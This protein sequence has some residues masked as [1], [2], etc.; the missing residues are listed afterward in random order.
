[1]SSWLMGSRV[2]WKSRMR[3]RKRLSAVTWSKCACPGLMLQEIHPATMLRL[4]CGCLGS[5]RLVVPRLA[6]PALV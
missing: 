1:M 6:A 3:V 4:L 5:I 2:G